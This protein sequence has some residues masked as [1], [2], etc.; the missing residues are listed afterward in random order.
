MG[1]FGKGAMTRRYRLLLLLVIRKLP[2][3]MGCIPTF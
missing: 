1:R 3:V 2:D